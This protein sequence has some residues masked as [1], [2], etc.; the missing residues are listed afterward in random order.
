MGDEFPEAA[1]EQ[2]VFIG[3]EAECGADEVG[4]QAQNPRD[5]LDS[6]WFQILVKKAMTIIIWTCLRPGMERR[7]LDRVGLECIPGKRRTWS[8]QWQ[9]GDGVDPG[10]GDPPQEKSHNQNFEFT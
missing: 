5:G 10:I 6:L 4:R 9:P 3:V 7:T 8:Q 1:F 2:L